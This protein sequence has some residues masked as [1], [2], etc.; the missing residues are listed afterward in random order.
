MRF[1]I[2]QDGAEQWRWR[3]VAKNNKT[4]ADGAEGYRSE[5]NVMR[6]VEGVKRSLASMGAAPIKVGE[7]KKLASGAAERNLRGLL[8][9][10]L[11]NDGKA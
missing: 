9:S 3:L 5:R 6:A 7:Y 2:Y 8:L 11:A 4:I 1:E 10:S